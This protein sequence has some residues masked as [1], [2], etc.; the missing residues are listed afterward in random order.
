MQAINADLENL[1]EELGAQARSRRQAKWEEYYRVYDRMTF[2]AVATMVL[3]ALVFGALVSLF[4]SRIAWDIGKLEARAAAVITGYRGAPLAVTRDDEIGGLMKAVNRMQSELRVHERQLELARQQQSHQEKMAAVGSLAAAVAHEVN[5]PIASI[6]GIARSM[7]AASSGTPGAN[8]DFAGDGPALILEQTRRIS[9]ITRQIAEF[10]RP[11]SPQ[12]ELI[13][14]NRLVQSICKFTGYDRRL[15][16]V[17][18]KLDLDPEMP[19]VECVADHVTQVLMNLLIN[20][21]DA[22]NAVAGRKPEIRITTR[23]VG[24][25][26]MLAVQDNGHGMD[27]ATRERAFEEGFSTKGEGQGLGLGLFLCKALVEGDGGRIEIDSNPGAGTTVS[28]RIPLQ[29]A[30]GP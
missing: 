15:H 21:G 6:A 10:T 11:H 29:P 20:A 26:A 2:V 19:A 24:E 18:M 13:D 23:R 7:A 9:E 22:L 14:L 12:P 28:F 17:P 4:F 8:G 5:N 25:Q 30:T 27:A 1:L 16:T 3:A